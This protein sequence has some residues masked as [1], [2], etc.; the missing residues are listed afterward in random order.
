MTQERLLDI[1]IAE[2]GQHGLEGAST[3]QIAAAAGTAMSSITYHYGGKEGLFLA[4]ADHI[5]A[6]LA[7][8]MGPALAHH[9]GTQVNTP[10]AARAALHMIVERFIDKMADARTAPWSLF[11]VREQMQPTEAFDR[12]YNGLMG[13]MLETLAR[14]VQVAGQISDDRHARLVVV[15]IIGQVIVMR[16]ARAASLRF[17]GHSD[18]DPVFTA[19]LKR[20]VAFNIDAVL[21]HL[22]ANRQESA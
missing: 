12:I 18:L 16:S 2:F 10:D 11:I 1:A 5:A 17:L 20:Q 4:A 8:D 22:A 13:R 14:L 6:R 7:E 15:T 19:D 21:D 3:R 9:A